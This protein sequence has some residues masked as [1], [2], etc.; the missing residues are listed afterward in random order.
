MKYDINYFGDDMSNILKDQIRNNDDLE[1]YL[2]DQIAFFNSFDQMIE[3]FI[4]KRSLNDLF[5]QRAIMQKHLH[6][7]VKA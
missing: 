2:Q 7:H 4:E 6:Y 3:K 1:M 5:D